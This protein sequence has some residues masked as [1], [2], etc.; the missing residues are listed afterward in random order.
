MGKYPLRNT[1]PVFKKVQSIY[2]NRLRIFTS[3]GQYKSLN[4]PNFYDRKVESSKDNISLEVYSVPNMERPLFKDVVPIAKWRPTERGESFGPSW[5]THWFRINITIP[6][7]WADAEQV[8]FK[9]DAGNEGMIYHADGTI[10]VGLSG[11]ER[12]EWILPKDWRDGQN[13]LFY[14]EMSCNGMFGNGTP[15]DIHPPDNNRWFSLN[16]VELVVPN[17]E[18]RALYIDFWIIGD[19][20]RELPDD[21]WQKHKAREVAN[22][23]MDTFDP[24]KPD[25]TIAECRKIATEYLGKFV[26]SSKVYSSPHSSEVVAIGNCHIDTAWLWPYAETRRKIARSWS[27]QLDLLERYPEYVFAASQAQQFQWLLEDHPQLFKRIQEAAK[28][29]RFIPVGG[30]WV[31]NDTN[32]PTGEAIVRQFLLGQRFFEEHFG[33]RSRT[34]WLPDTF[35]YSAQIPQ[36][37]RGAEMDRFLTQKL[38]WNNINKFPNTTFNWVAL[39]GSQVICHMPPDDTYTAAAHFGDVWRSLKQQKNMDVCHSGMLLYGHGDGGGGPTAEMLEK[40]RRCRGMADTVGSIPRVHSGTTVDEFYNEISDYTKDG[41]DLVTWVGE[42]YFEFHR[43]TYTTQSDTKKH[44][45]RSEIILHD[46]E[47][48]STLASLANKSY[49]Y[50]KKDIDELWKDVCLNQFHDVLPGSSIEMVYDDVKIIY[51]D[52]YKRSEKL[53]TEALQALGLSE[54]PSASSSGNELV[55][56]N[57]MP[58]RRVEVIEVPTTS[59]ILTSQKVSAIQQVVSPESRLV[60]VETEKGLGVANCVSENALL[61]DEIL[62]KVSV[63]EVEP[64]VFILQNQLLRAR[65]DGGHVTSLYD[66]EHDRELIPKGQVGN[67]LVLFDDQPLYWQAW[68][69]ELYSLDARHELGKGQGK[70]TKSGPLRAEIEVTQ[71]ISETSHIVTKI[72]LDA[73]VKTFDEKRVIEGSQLKFSCKVEWNE[74]CKF[75]KVEFPFD[76]V[77]DTASYETQFGIV[78]RPTH[79]NT[80][81][82]VAKFEVCGHKWGDLSEYSHGVALL[83]DC[84]YGYAIHG[85]TVRLSLLRA[86]KA[87]DAHADIGTHTFTYSLLP[88]EGGVSHHVVRAAYNLNHPL[89]GLYKDNSTLT[90]GTKKVSCSKVLGDITLKGEPGLI[91]STIKRFED[92]AEVHYGGLPVRSQKPSAIVRVYESLGGKSRGTLNI[93]TTAGGTGLLPLVTKVFKT[94]LLEDDEEEVKFTQVND[95]NNAN[96]K[97]F[98]IEI[99]VELGAFQVGTYR[100]EF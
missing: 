47:F 72:S 14:I 52:V 39:D 56:V 58:W 81:W 59:E 96:G 32:M 19:A 84:K 68:D 15:D 65:I 100:L 11:Q 26:N 76:L 54:K 33:T 94:N 5:S 66:I 69:T 38:S 64:N 82:D 80:S 34:F 99:P 97:R 98:W 44:N 57:T 29:G 75:L 83:N 71:K 43:G 77:S 63:E 13:H 41:K 40:L 23:I 93:G 70:I 7:D 67:K 46:L 16:T 78:K 60:L 89:K 18:A 21:S 3:D 1:A 27:S 73:Y 37:C 61:I 79:F 17:L 50:P 87:P 55:A 28:E 49:K 51:A 4:L 24:N 86:P 2:E 95:S 90:V 35:G 6:Q 42:L 10:V 48:F 53:T 74:D 62:T 20:A 91:L 8:I 22:L 30:S 45:R 85:Q 88:H 12:R 25:E 31:E 36:L 92:D 9:W